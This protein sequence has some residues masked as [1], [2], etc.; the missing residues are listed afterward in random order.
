[1]ANLNETIGRLARPLTSLISL[2]AD[3]GY[4][5]LDIGSSSIKMVEVHGQG[6]TLKITNAGIIPLHSDAV[7][8]H[9]VQ[10]IGQVTQAIRTLVEENRV[11]TQ[12]VVAAV[13]G[14]AVIVKPVSFPAQDLAA[15]EETILFEA[16]NFIPES[17]DNVNLDYQ[18]LGRDPATDNIDRA[19]SV[20][21]EQLLDEIQRSLSFFWTAAT[22]ETGLDTSSKLA[23]ALGQM[24]ALF[25]R[26]SRGGSWSKSTRPTFQENVGP[27]SGHYN[28][29]LRTSPLWV[30]EPTRTGRKAVS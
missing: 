3:K 20:T 26:L 10:D 9:C 23:S 6:S 19:L 13:P 14:P 15:L 22:E 28:L 8:S 21:S 27:G 30:A 2:G 11:R 18:V 16:G 4:L 12:E 7:Q 24:G 1:M 5:S 17:L 25:G 29:P